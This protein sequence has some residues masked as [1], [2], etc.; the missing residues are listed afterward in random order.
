MSEMTISQ[1]ARHLI[2]SRHSYVAFDLFY[3]LITIMLI[4]MNSKKFKKMV[5]GTVGLKLVAR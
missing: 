1:V 5:V 2:D 3:I 4:I